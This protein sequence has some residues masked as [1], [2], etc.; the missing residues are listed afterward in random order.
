MEN[1]RTGVLTVKCGIRYSRADYRPVR[2]EEMP[3]EYRE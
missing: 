2:P 3:A 1:L